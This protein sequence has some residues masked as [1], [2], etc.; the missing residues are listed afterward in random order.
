MARKYHQQLNLIQN[1]TQAQAREQDQ[2][3][4]QG[5][6]QAPMILI[7]LQGFPVAITAD[8]IR[9]VEVIG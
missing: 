1:L 2:V 4:D 9:I 6:G 5:P 8:G 7:F 3:Q